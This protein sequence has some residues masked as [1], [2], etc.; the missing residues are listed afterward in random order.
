MQ[1]VRMKMYITQRH[2]KNMCQVIKFNVHSLFVYVFY[3]P[4]CLVTLTHLFFLLFFF[5][6]TDGAEMH[7]L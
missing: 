6:F 3:P 1:T 7:S 2:L 4:T 5:L